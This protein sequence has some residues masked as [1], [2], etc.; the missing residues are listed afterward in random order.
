M[1]VRSQI[2]RSH[3]YCRWM[4]PPL[5]QVQ[6]CLK[7]T[8][9]EKQL[10]VFFYLIDLFTCREKQHYRVPGI[11]CNQVGTGKV[12]ATVG[13]SPASSYHLH[14]LQRPSVSAFSELEPPPISLASFLLGRHLCPKAEGGKCCL[15]DIYPSCQDI[16]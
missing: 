9:R 14:R 2:Q 1:P 12:A 3:S 16:Q 5:G 8:I 10:F 7:G 15:I 4:H 6:W 11:V 13:G